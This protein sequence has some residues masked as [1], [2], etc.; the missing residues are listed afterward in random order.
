MEN[1]IDSR[2]GLTRSDS[3]NG[4]GERRADRTLVIGV[5]GEED[6]S[7]RLRLSVDKSVSPDSLRLLALSLDEGGVG[8]F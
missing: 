6:E 4:T 3:V 1:R 7:F 2:D 8:S 5:E